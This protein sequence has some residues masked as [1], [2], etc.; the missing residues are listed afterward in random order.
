D[1][2]FFFALSWSCLSLSG[3]FDVLCSCVLRCNRSSSLART[4]M[5]T[6]TSFF[7]NYS[8]HRHDVDSLL[9]LHLRL[10][11]GARIF[12]VE[13][14]GGLVEI[15]RQMHGRTRRAK[16]RLGGEPDGRTSRGFGRI[17][18]NSSLQ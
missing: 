15:F 16:Q 14:E 3:S 17:F 5:E 10:C 9:E 18:S 4:Q 7:G 2:I 11:I 13:Q 8:L 12:H 6:N 1:F